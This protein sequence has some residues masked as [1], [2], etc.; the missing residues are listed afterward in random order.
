MKLNLLGVLRKA[1]SV[2]WYDIGPLRGIKQKST[3]H[4]G[5]ECVLLDF[6]HG[7]FNLKP[8]CRMRSDYNIHRDTFCKE[9]VAGTASLEMVWIFFSTLLFTSYLIIS[10]GKRWVWSANKRCLN[11][12]APGHIIQTLGIV[13]CWQA[14]T[15]TNLQRSFSKDECDSFARGSQWIK[16][17]NACRWSVSLVLHNHNWCSTFKKKNQLESVSQEHWSKGFSL[18]HQS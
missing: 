1:L 16:K 8:W 17:K 18:S 6:L 13:L 10:G 4:L 9:P 12:L 14:S 2:V 3:W 7:S 5:L 15:W 11:K